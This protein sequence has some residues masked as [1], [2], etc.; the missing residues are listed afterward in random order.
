MFPATSN[1]EGMDAPVASYSRDV[2][3]QLDAFLRDVEGRAYR[4]TLLQVKDRD[5]ALDIVQDAMIALVRRYARR[6]CE[7]W[8][9]LFFR[10]LRN[11]TRDWFRR[12]AVKRR[13]MGWLPS[14]DRVC[15]ASLEAAPAPESRNPLA[16]LSQRAAIEALQAALS[17]LPARQREAFMLRSLEGLDVR[18]TAIAMQC[19]QG[20]VKT[21]YSRALVR[22][23]EIIGDH[24]HE[25]S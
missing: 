17:E 7:Q 13:V 24:W 11:R 1:A 20:S 12:Q 25:H 9:P 23:R 21:H 19:S 8:P 15:E 2:R 10:I 5:E 3:R 16:E 4:L 6:P 22:L 14:G 18:E